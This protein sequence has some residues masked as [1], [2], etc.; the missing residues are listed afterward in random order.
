VY[1]YWA[2]L[3]AVFIAGSD[4]TEDAKAFSEQAAAKFKTH[5]RVRLAYY[6]ACGMLFQKTSA[7]GLPL[8]V[9]EALHARFY[10]PHSLLPA[11]SDNLRSFVSVGW[12][13]ALDEKVA[14]FVGQSPFTTVVWV[15][16]LIRP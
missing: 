1:K 9:F 7:P 3:V 11:L 14:Q 5:K 13:A 16:F 4:K 8:K 12:L 15:C 2:L 10:I 6:Y